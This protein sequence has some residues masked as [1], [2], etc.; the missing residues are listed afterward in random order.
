MDYKKQ[1]YI[2]AWAIFAVSS[3]VYLMTM[4]PNVSFWDCGEFAA[5]AYT[6][7]V[8]HPPGAPLWTIIGKV[9]ALFPLGSNPAVKINTVS[10]ISSGF[11]VM[12]LYLVLVMVIKSWK[13][14]P[15][16]K[17]E[18][19]TV[20]AASAIGA[21]SY[22]FCDSFWFNALEA[23]VYS[24]GTTL[25]ALSIWLILYWRE[26]FEKEGIDKILLLFVFISGLAL[27]IHLLVTQ[28][29]LMA[30]LIYYF[31]KFEYSRKGLLIAFLITCGAFLVVY[32]VITLWYPSLLAGNLQIF[33]IQDSQVIRWIAILIIPALIFG[34]I[35]A[36]KKNKRTWNLAFTSILLIILGY[37][38]YTVI[39]LRARVDNLPINENNPQN[40]ETLVSYLNREQ[41][42]SA[43]FW[44]RRYSHDP[45]H[46]KTWT[47][48]SGD[49][50]FMWRYQVNQMFNRYLGWQYIGR[51]GYN[52]N[53]G[54]DWSKFYGIPFLLGL[55]GLFYHFRKDWKLG[56][57][58][59]WLFL[60]TGVISALFQRQ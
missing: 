37:S 36:H 54:I 4:Q 26:N 44:P 24:F 39:L 9:A 30:G 7:S 52:M 46:T 18:A 17:W 5:C 29:I 21:L 59:L 34:M 32:P 16:S 15:K 20:S 23:E 42:G 28:V 27:G 53:Q 11:T 48:Y 58:F 55:I 50:D 19:F 35:R 33:R 13:G 2:V 47:N 3:I 49:F 6:L 8:P 12:I 25:V 10:A 40:M 43:P 38:I 14:L 1:N 51:A 41:Y 45:M 57:S 31:R 56:L 22:A 60:L